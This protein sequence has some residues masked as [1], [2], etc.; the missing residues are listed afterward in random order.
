MASIK[1]RVDGPWNWQVVQSTNTSSLYGTITGTSYVYDNAPWNWTTT[2][3][4][5]TAAIINW[6]SQ[7]YR[8]S[9]AVWHDIVESEAERLARE[10]REAQYQ[11][12]VRRENVEREAARVEAE[13]RGEE[14][15]LGQ[16]DDE[17][18][19]RWNKERK[20]HVHSQRGRRYCIDGRK[21]QHN[22]FELDAEGVPVKELCVHIALECPLTDNVLAQ[23]L[24]LEHAEDHLIERANIWDLSGSRR[25]VLAH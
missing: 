22:V 2:A 3:S 6:E 14:L 13:R 25:R 11:E 16:L 4:N 21:R 7:G 9:T 15:L 8:R 17:E 10:E 1:Y 19:E 23:K 5:S 24:A 18:I 20:I 12:R